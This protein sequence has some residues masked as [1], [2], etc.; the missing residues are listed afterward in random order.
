MNEDTIGAFLLISVFANIMMLIALCSSYDDMKM[1]K[2]EAIQS[3][4]AYYDV[5]SLGNPKFTW[6][7]AEK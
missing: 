5:D 2:K 7:N 4:R 6:K 3:N 1:V